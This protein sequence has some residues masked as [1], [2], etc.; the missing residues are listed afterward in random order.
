MARTTIR[1]LLLELVEE[2]ETIETTGAELTED[3]VVRL[4][5]ALAKCGRFIE[6]PI[7]KRVA[8]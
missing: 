3:S 1:L 4:K 7:R 2:S 6:L 8:K 5:P